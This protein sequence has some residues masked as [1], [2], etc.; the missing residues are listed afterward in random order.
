MGVHLVKIK[1]N[2]KNEKHISGIHPTKWLFLVN[3]LTFLDFRS[4]MD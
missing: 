4:E 3:S 1:Y 2:K